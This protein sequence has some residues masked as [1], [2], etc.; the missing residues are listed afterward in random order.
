MV[1]VICCGQ[2]FYRKQETLT[3]LKQ[4]NGLYTLK[5]GDSINITPTMEKFRLGP[6][7]FK[8]LVNLIEGTLEPNDLTSNELLE[9][10]KLADFLNAPKPLISDLIKI[11][12]KSNNRQLAWYF[13]TGLPLVVTQEFS[14]GEIKPWLGILRE[15]DLDKEFRNSL[16]GKTLISRMADEATG[17][18]SF[19]EG[20]KPWEKLFNVFFSQFEQD[21]EKLLDALNF[22]TTPKR[23]CA[24]AKALI[25]LIFKRYPPN[26]EELLNAIPQPFFKKRIAP[27]VSACMPCLKQIEPMCW[28]PTKIKKFVQWIPVNETEHLFLLKNDK[29]GVWD[30][31][32]KKY[33]TFKRKRFQSLFSPSYFKKKKSCPE[34][35]TCKSFGMILR[36]ITMEKYN[37]KEPSKIISSFQQLCTRSIAP[38]EKLS[39]QQKLVLL[40]IAS[41]ETKEALIKQTEL[42][43]EL[44]NA[45]LPNGKIILKS[46]SEKISARDFA[47]NAIEETLEKKEK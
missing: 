46:W 1:E 19:H 7:A 39:P 16:L 37:S 43:K 12:E 11:V 33:K 45:L 40:A 20:K 23:E 35:Y 3:K 31:K 9:Q 13:F 17:V 26:L 47:Q 28:E 8:K 27:A 32:K 25:S 29:M 15:V 2:R 6:N 42:P 10:L 41:N 34:E 18:L 38:L 22:A 14:R 24:Y 30:L 5:A 36:N 4:L 21:N 44:K